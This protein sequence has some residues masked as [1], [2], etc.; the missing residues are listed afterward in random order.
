MI[1]C[2][3][4]EQ[5]VYHQLDEEEDAIWSLLVASGYLKVLACEKRVSGRRQLYDLALTNGEV[6]DMFYNMVRGW[7]G[8]GKAEYN[9][10]V[11]ALLACD[12]EQMNDYMA[13]AALNLFSYFDT[14]NRPSG[15]EPER[16]YHGFVLGLI[17]DLHEDY[18]ITSN[19]ESGFGRYDVMIE[20]KNRKQNAY[21]LEFKVF[22]AR[23]ERSLQDTVDAAHAQIEE[24]KYEAVLLEKGFPA[25][26]IH[27]YAFAFRG[28]QVLIG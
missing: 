14:G 15:T 24:R 10:F 2:P 4:N 11:T 5:V 20:P 19:G 12:V 23:H 8:T 17:V 9:G 22:H 26:N 27:K 1:R 28:K 16:F 18:V 3:V 7:F 6:R 25:E 21:I 13:R